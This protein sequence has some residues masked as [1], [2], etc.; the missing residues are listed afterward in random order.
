MSD[1]ETEEEKGSFKVRD[2]RIFT[3]EGAV[4]DDLEA[5]A[6]SEGISQPEVSAAPE[7][8]PESRE[9]EPVAQ[10]EEPEEAMNFSSLL[11]FLATT[12]MVHLGEIPEPTTG[13]RSENLEG[14]RQMI[15]LLTILMEKTEGNLSAE[16]VHLLEN[17]LYEL[18]MKFLDKSKAVEL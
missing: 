7:L 6:E 1:F 14:A 11:L 3:S 10:P 16:E 15:D 5:E 17:L 8:R 12:G 9:K 18:R 2:R 13:Q 4:R